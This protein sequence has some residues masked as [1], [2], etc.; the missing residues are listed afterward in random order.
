MRR[1][2]ANSAYN[3]RHASC[4]QAVELLRKTKTWVRLLG[5]LPTF[6]TADRKI[7]MVATLDIGRTAA[8]ALLH[9]AEGKKVI[10][11][12]GPEDYSPLEIAAIVTLREGTID[13][14]GGPV[15]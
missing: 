14:F 4:E 1:S 6:L 2:L 10:E 9:P 11:L 12:S 5:V 15:A 8:E 3:E 7:P 13:I